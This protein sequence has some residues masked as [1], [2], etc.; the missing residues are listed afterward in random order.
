M[1]Q[2]RLCCPARNRQISSLHRCGLLSLVVFVGEWHLFLLKA[3]VIKNFF[4]IQ[5]IE[6][7]EIIIF[8]DI[9]C[10]ERAAVLCI[11]SHRFLILVL[12]TRDRFRPRRR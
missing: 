7:S 9:Q 1:N 12:V 10:I 6:A 5:I 3:F 2:M 11:R 8:L 4:T